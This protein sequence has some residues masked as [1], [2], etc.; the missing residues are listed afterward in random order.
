MASTSA[1]SPGPG[2]TDSEG[3]GTEILVG[4]LLVAAIVA[5]VALLAVYWSGGQTQAEG[6]LLSASLGCL[7]VAVGLWARHFMPQGPYREERPVLGST[8]DDR[9]AVAADFDA[10]ERTVGRRRVLATLLVGAFAALGAFA[11]SPIRSLGPAPLGDLR[12]TAW[13]PGRRLVDIDGRPVHRDELE[14]DTVITV[15]PE[16]FDRADEAD[17]Q[18]LLIRLAPG[19]LQ[20][21]EGRETWAP[22]GYVAF[23]KV[24]THAGCPVGLYEAESHQLV[25]PCH[26]SLFDVAAAA[27]PVFGPAT[28]A[29]PQLPLEVDG[30][31]YLR[32]QGDFPVPVGPG[33]WSWSE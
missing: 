1:G 23:S 9:A 6:A 19:V 29:L 20:A 21:E 3:R 17:S 27:A 8:A 4:V 5:G 16:G 28:R 31:G 14:V 22:D 33:F 32:A 26:Q 7:T 13:A 24:C 25:C 12:R 10:G 2:T 11:L 15:L 18:T 30:D